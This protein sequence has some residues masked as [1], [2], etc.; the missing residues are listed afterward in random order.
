MELELQPF[1]G[2]LRD[3]MGKNGKEKALITKKVLNN[4][5]SN[6]FIEFETNT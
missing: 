4:V 2:L 6:I 3:V 5:L 1:I